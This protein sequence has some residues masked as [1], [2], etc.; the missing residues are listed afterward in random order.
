VQPSFWKRHRA[1]RWIVGIALTG[2]AVLILVV[3]IL[4]RRTEP[5]LRARIVDELSSRF[6]AKVE[7]DTFHLSFGNGFR[8]EWGIW[9]RGRGL[10][11]WPSENA[12]AAGVPNSPVISLDEFRFHAPLRY[13]PGV[14]IHISEVRLNGLEIHLPPKPHELH[15][16]LPKPAGSPQDSSTTPFVTFRVDRVIAT[17]CHLVHETDKPGK[18]P[19]DFAITSLVLK[20][21]TPNRVMHFEAHLIN[22]RPEGTIHTTGTFGPW[23]SSDPGESAVEGNYRFE[24]A[25]LATFKQIAGTLNSDGHYEGTLNNIDATG[26]TDTPDFQLPQF[27]N[28]MHLR[29]Q[30]HATVDGT[31]GDTWLNSVDAT[32]GQSR[33]SVKG[34]VVRFL[35][36]GDDPHSIGHDVD[37]RVIINN[38][39]IEDFT[40]LATHGSEPLLTGTLNLDAKMNIPPGQGVMHER[41]QMKGEFVLDDAEFTNP[42]VQGKLKQLSLRGQGKTNELKSTDP[43]VIP[44]H[45]EGYFDVA[46]GKIA[47]PSL[48]FRVPGAD[49]QLK[50]IYGLDGGSLDFIGSARMDATISKM[51]G[52]WKGFLLKPADR[53]FKKDGAG[54]S[55]PIRVG[56][57]AS[58]PD[59]ALDFHR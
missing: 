8:G 19:L 11:V 41:L 48:Q 54:T 18:L 47:F 20:D 34:K 30:F 2:L 26:E 55:L 45:L 35:S 44:A 12:I 37:L 56:G 5:F 46:T 31:N 3:V 25:N 28:A 16:N 36:K 33:F 43:M 40:R 49:I 52:G 17:N 39:R 58:H 59:I 9:A 13:K 38:G 24:N 32:L 4:A 7:L 50:G 21:F 27:G 57:V 42:G 6:H 51:V 1:L 29:T 14:P 15:F 53:F 10:R 23:D 22:P